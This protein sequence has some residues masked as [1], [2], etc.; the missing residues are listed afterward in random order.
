MR[1]DRKEVQQVS[2]LSGFGHSRLAANVC[3]RM[4]NQIYG[5]NKKNI[6]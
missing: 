4:F 6:E 3:K 5:K 2:L 1:K